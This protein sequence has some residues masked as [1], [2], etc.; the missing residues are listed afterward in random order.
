MPPPDSGEEQ[1]TNPLPGGGLHWKLLASFGGFGYAPIASGT[2]GTLPAVAIWWFLSPHLDAWAWLALCVVT[3]ALS[4]WVAHRAGPLFG[5]TDAGEI[6]ID[7]VA[8]F[9]WTMT[10]APHDW[11]W[12]VMGFFAFRF[13]DILKPWPASYFDQK[14][15]NGFGVTMDD[16][17]AGAFACV[18]LHTMAAFANAL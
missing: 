9:F 8:G 3:T 17:V 11:R 10:L 14:V 5:Q 13:F 12:G 1:P 18:L 6:V 15:K 16:V 4:T 2:F 7:E